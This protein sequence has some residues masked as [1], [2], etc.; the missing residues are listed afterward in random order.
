MCVEQFPNT[1]SHHINI[2][3]HYSNTVFCVVVFH[4]MP[5]IAQSSRRGPV[6]LTVTWCGLEM[7]MM[8]SL[9]WGRSVMVLSFLT[10]HRRLGK[11]GWVE[12]VSRCLHP[13]GNLTWTACLMPHILMGYFIHRYLFHRPWYIIEPSLICVRCITVARMSLSW[14]WH[15][16][17]TVKLIVLQ[18]VT[19]FH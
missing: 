17:W 1:R 12:V 8:S 13:R 11:C 9:P 3:M 18:L 4:M 16:C 2:L 10:C 19:W 15:R 6:G 5:I 7:M 14:W